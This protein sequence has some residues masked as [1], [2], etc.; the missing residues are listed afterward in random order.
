MHFEGLRI[1]WMC[2]EKKWGLHY[3]EALSRL[4]L[5]YEHANNGYMEK[6]DVSLS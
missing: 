5:M 1:G 4:L 3:Y 2:Q 6:E